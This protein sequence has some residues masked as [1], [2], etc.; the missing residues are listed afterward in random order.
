MD[1]KTYCPVCERSGVRFAPL[2]D[3]YRQN[4]LLHGFK[5]FGRAETIAL[6]NYSCM[7]CG[8]SD[9]ERLYA[10]WINAQI[11]SGAL[12]TGARVV[13]F[14]PEAALSKKIRKLDLFDYKTADFMM[15]DVDFQI[16]LMNI[17]FEDEYCD[18]F[19]C[20][21]VLEH[22]SDDNLAVRELARITRGDGCGILMAPIC[23]DIDDTLEDPSATSDGDR[24]RLFGQDDHVRLYS[25]R[26]YVN[27]LERNG[28]AVQQLDQKVIGAN[29]INH[30]GLSPTSILYIVTRPEP[31]DGAP[32]NSSKT[33]S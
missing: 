24:W 2:P 14:A 21:H 23:V 17:P 9:R 4:S 19:I 26:G 16:D 32:L 7:T 18:F 25:H 3:D 13:H 30:L 1:A 5:H 11:E 27:T 6:N 10:W 31:Q 15:A 28:F 12:K 33:L 8:A 29:L 20:S 22:V